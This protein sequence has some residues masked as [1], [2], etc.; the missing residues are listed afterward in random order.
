MDVDT[1]SVSSSSENSS[2]RTKTIG[3]NEEGQ[4]KCEL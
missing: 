2:G 1:R 4:S 3:G